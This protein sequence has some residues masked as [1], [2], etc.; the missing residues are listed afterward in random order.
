MNKPSKLGHLVRACRQVKGFTQREL[1][2]RAGM[3]QS[4][5]AEIESG[6]ISDP[7]FMSVKKLLN[8]MDY[9][10]EVKAVPRK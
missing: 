2:Q 9:D 7:R 8:A 5:V 4:H 3:N 6:G 10:L 1:A